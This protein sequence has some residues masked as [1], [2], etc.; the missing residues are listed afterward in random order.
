MNLSEAIA[1]TTQNR[2]SWSIGKGAPTRLEQ[3]EHVY[4]NPRL[5]KAAIEFPHKLHETHGSRIQLDQ[6]AVYKGRKSRIN[7]FCA[8]CG[9]HWSPLA[10]SL[11]QGHGCPVCARSKISQTLTK[12]DTRTSLGTTKGR[13]TVVKEPYKKQTAGGRVREHL[14]LNCSCGKT[15]E[16]A[17]SSFLRECVKSCGCLKRAR[18][19]RYKDLT[20]QKFG[21]LLVLGYAGSAKTKA[22]RQSVFSVQCSCGR[23]AFNVIGRSLLTGNTKSCHTC[24]HREIG[25]KSRVSRKG[26]RFGM[27][28]V[29]RDWGSNPT[30][31]AKSLCQCDCGV[32]I[33]VLTSGLVTGNTQTCGN[34][35]EGHARDTRENLLLD[36]DWAD[37]PCRVYLA[38]VNGNYLKPGIAKDEAQRAK[39]SGGFYKGYQFVSPTLTRAEAWA[40]E[41]CLLIESSCAK[42]VKL[43]QEYADWGGRTELRLKDVLPVSWYIERF[44][45]LLE[46]LAEM[47]WQE[48]Y[49]QHQH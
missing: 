24:G 1:F 11:L 23:E 34:H 49:L 26:Q 33:V 20:G 14:L 31:K 29:L 22:G 19:P 15:V 7:V 5:A 38:N 44:H 6:T 39:Q 25:K 18:S 21:K 10:G 13:L 4:S 30:G 41:Q 28:T 17:K 27:L 2:E 35:L 37:S 32:Q 36:P 8:V 46:L 40:I 48:L 9:H 42:P 43:P 12:T 45:Q 3:A 47:G 16:M